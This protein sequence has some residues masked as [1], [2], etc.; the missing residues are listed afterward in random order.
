MF[1]NLVESNSHKDDLARKSSF[2]FGTV[3]IY[4]V[5]GLIAFTYIIIRGKAELDANDDLDLT[6]LVAPVPVPPQQ[7]QPEQK[8]A[9]KPAERANQPEVAQRTEFVANVDAPIVPK[10]VS[11]VAS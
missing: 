4:L 9:P 2:F 8:E 10:T 3:M 11:A 5:L 1:D 7:A 6:A